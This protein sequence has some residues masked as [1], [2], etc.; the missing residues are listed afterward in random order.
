[1]MFTI[2]GLPMLIRAVQGAG[3]LVQGIKDA[4][5]IDSEPMARVQGLY[6]PQ[7]LRDMSAETLE[8]LEKGSRRVTLAD[9]ARKARR[10]A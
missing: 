8:I 1:M 2:Y 10:A 6:T 3:K 5:D 4:Q 7:E 9:Q